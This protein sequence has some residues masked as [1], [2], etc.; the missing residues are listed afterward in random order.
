MGLRDTM[1]ESVSIILPVHNQAEHIGYVVEN[2]LEALSRTPYQYEFLMVVN[3]CHDNSL[4]ICRK[5]EA[6]HQFIRVIFSEDGGWG[7]AVRL[8]LEAAHGNYLCYTN[9]A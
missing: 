1:T 5:L 4:E 3:A 8:G 2:Y 6:T 9:S 7:L